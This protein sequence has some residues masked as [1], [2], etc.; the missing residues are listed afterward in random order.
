MNL[1]SVCVHRLFTTFLV[2]IDSENLD[3]SMIHKNSGFW[4]AYSTD[5]QGCLHRT[6]VNYVL[7]QKGSCVKICKCDL[8]GII[9]FKWQLII[10]SQ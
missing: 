5:F 4:V 8:P 10:V 3:Y 6:H 7:K 9:Q 1:Y 2:G